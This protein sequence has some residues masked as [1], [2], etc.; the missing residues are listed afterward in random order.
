METL[1]FIIVAGFFAFVY[2]KLERMEIKI[3]NLEDTVY[4]LKAATPKC[5]SDRVDK[6]ALL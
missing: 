3:D 6:E 5:N 2:Q 1:F 4:L